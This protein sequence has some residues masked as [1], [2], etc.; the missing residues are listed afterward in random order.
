MYQRSLEGANS[1]LLGLISLVSKISKDAKQSI[2]KVA[3][4]IQSTIKIF[5][6]EQSRIWYDSA[7]HINSLSS[8]STVTISNSTKGNGRNGIGSNSK[9]L[10]SNDDDAIDIDK[11]IYWRVI[12]TDTSSR[13]D[14][15]GCNTT[16]IATSNTDDD[17]SRY[18]HIVHDTSALG[19][20][21]L[22]IDAT[23]YSMKGCIRYCLISDKIIKSNTNYV[24]TWE[25]GTAVITYNDMM[26][27]YS[28]DSSDYSD[29]RYDTPVHTID[30]RKEGSVVAAI[31]FPVNGSTDNSV[32][33]LN[34]KYMFSVCDTEVGCK[35]MKLT[36]N[37]LCDPSIDPPEQRED[38]DY[39]IRYSAVSKQSFDSIE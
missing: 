4:L 6:H 12:D 34:N 30:F 18:E 26:Y 2:Q 38:A 13:I 36:S 17:V 15:G 16:D 19:V 10:R 14:G 7:T 21:I 11:D 20:P 9:V 22:S 32:W 3:S 31:I 28:K 8:L 23:T 5:A 35:W 24:V 39:L 37:P 33:T 1:T 27:I 29:T 25:E